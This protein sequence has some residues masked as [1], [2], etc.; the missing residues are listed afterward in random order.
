MILGA[1]F[2]EAHERDGWPNSL[3]T[4]KD[5]R[6]N[7]AKFMI[8]QGFNTTPND[9]K[10]AIDLG[11]QEIILR[12]EDDDYTPQRVRSDLIDRGFLCF[13]DDHP[14]TQFWLEVGNEQDVARLDPWVGR[15]W[16]IRLATEMQWLRRSNLRFVASMPTKIDQVDVYLTRNHEGAVVDVYDAIAVHAYGDYHVA[17]SGDWNKIIERVM[18]VTPKPILI[19]EFGINHPLSSREKATRYLDWLR[20]LPPRVVSA[21]VYWLGTGARNISY[22]V[23]PQM[24]DVLRTFHDDDQSESG[25]V[26]DAIEHV[27]AFL[28]SRYSDFKPMK[29]ERDSND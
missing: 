4:F 2:A 1:H 19:T 22:Q 3:Q 29:I 12:T 5:A 6:F 17:D 27:Q 16:Q 11:A 26:A 18:H 7:G 25:S 13:V 8:P 9:V 23:T 24:A 21:Y 10:R 15:F 28:A 20:T 14:S